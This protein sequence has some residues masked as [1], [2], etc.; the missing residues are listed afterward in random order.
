MKSKLFERIE[1]KN[2]ITVVALLLWIGGSVWGVMNGKFDDVFDFF[3][4]EFAIII[5][6]YFGYQI[7]KN[8]KTD[9]TELDLPPESE[10]YE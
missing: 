8:E 10:D 2:C 4:N 7:K 5:G 3:K 6:V 1:I 9:T